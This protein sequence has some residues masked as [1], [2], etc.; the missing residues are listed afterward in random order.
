MAG[1]ARESQGERKMRNKRIERL[2]QEHGCSRQW[3]YQLLKKQRPKEKVKAPK[4][5][6]TK[7]HELLEEY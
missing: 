4:A 5:P 6:N 1:K 7:H 3:A 2:M